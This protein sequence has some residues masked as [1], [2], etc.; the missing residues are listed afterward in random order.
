MEE[1]IGRVKMQKLVGRNKDSL[2]GKAKAACVSKAKEGIH[3]LP[4]IGRQVFSR[5]QE[6]RA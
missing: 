2:T 3:S 1:S 5:F 4:P 6:S